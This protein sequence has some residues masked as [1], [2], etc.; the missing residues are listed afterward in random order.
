MIWASVA[1]AADWADR[2]DTARQLRWLEVL[3][4]ERDFEGIP[5]TSRHVSHPDRERARAFLRE[6]LASLGLDVVEEPF[7]A[8]GIEGVNLIVTLRG[9]EPDLEPL[10]VS[11]HY[12][13]TAALTDGFDPAV[14]PAPGADDDASGCA[15]VL[16]AATLLSKEPG[17][18]R[19]IEFIFFDAE[20][21]GL[22]GSIAH[23]EQRTR[24]VHGMLS[25]DSV[26]SNPADGWVFL[27][28]GTGAEHLQQALVDA[29]LEQTLRVLTEVRSVGSELIGP[30]R[31]DHGPFIEAGLPAAH[32]GQFPL[33]ASYHTQDD[34]LSGLDRDFIAD[35]TAVVVAALE[36]LAEPYVDAPAAGGCSTAPARSML[37]AIAGRSLLRPRKR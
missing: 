29:S 19:S 1:L 36:Q 25:V 27:S 2:V 23:V 34:V 6:E 33:P 21:A 26:G 35:N 7:R 10:V 37:Q 16:E 32:L 22:V 20:E 24:G 17:F 13:S 8:E 9:A 30:P 12:D 31:S 18:R 3:A 11:A 4:G 5:I 14:D 28:V 15:L